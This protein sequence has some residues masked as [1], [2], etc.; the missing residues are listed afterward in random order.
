MTRPL[1]TVLAI[2]YNRRE[3]IGSALQSAL[4]QTLSRDLYEIVLVT[5]FKVSS[6]ILYE[7]NI[8]V[9]FS[10]IRELGPKLASVIE[11][12]QGD[13]ISILEDDDIWLPEK[14]EHVKSVFDQFPYVCY[15]HN[16]WTV[17]DTDGNDIYHP[18]H[19]QGRRKI[20]SLK[21]YMLFSQRASYSNIRKAVHLTG[22][23]NGS[24]IS[25]K[26]SVILSVIDYLK[27][28]TFSPD[29]F[30]FYSALFYEGD[31]F[32]DSTILTKYRIHHQNVTRRAA[33]IVD[34]LLDPTHI[35][36]TQMLHSRPNK[37]AALKSI[38]CQMSDI[39]IES[40]WIWGLKNRQKGLRL[41][42]NHL[43]YISAPEFGYS[44]LL[45]AFSFLYGISPSI[46]SSIYSKIYYRE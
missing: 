35:I 22:D 6:P 13:I 43:K 4:R 15:Y 31:M 9:I 5:N 37:E 46:A 28:I 2:A 39:G 42:L 14:L 44:F 20:K 1:I 34:A 45:I 26:K 36:I 30:L 40:L 41:A 29:S 7:G 32:I 19:I 16:N 38:E 8:R 17:I 23:F 12:C 18:I 25:V 11:Q 21:E 3:F 27:Q 33:G 10:D 24:S